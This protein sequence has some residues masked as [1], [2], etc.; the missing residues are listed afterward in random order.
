MGQGFISWALLNIVE[1][2]LFSA[3]SINVCDAESMLRLSAIP[4]PPM[5]QQETCQPIRF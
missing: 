1:M 3:S 5:R 2:P 4:S